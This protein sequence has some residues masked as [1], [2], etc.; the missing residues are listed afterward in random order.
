MIL[1]TF[2][3]HNRQA[4][5]GAVN[6][7]ESLVLDLKLA[8]RLVETSNS[9]DFDSMLDL[10]EGGNN[11]LEK[12]RKLVAEAAWEGP[13]VY[14][15]SELKLLSPIPL[16]PQIR[17]FSVTEQHVRQAMAGLA[18]IRAKRMGVLAPTNVDFSVP[19]VV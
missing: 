8:N 15:L 3:A 4:A 13:A 1:A 11:T 2:C 6:R 17:D 7:E 9:S 10:I 18:R 19:E 12:T 16:P 14:R 5:V